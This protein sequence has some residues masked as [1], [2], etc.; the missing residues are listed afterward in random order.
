VYPTSLLDRLH[1]SRAC[2]PLPD[3]STWRC[4][5][6]DDEGEV[7]ASCVPED[8]G[9]GVSLTVPEDDEVGGV[10][11]LNRPCAS[12][13]CM[14]ALWPLRPPPPLTCKPSV[15]PRCPPLASIP[16]MR[17]LRPRPPLPRKARCGHSG[18]SPPRKP[19]CGASRCGAV[20]WN[21]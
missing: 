14:A 12:R 3:G 1:P 13:F 21:R 6:A 18:C 15:R 19:R 10:V 16:S 11:D 20:G 2:L 5:P 9:V 17:P 8:D 4:R 7:V